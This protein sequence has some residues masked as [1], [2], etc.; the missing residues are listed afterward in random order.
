MVGVVQA[1]K[2]EPPEIVKP[3]GNV[4]SAFGSGL[5]H[6]RSGT[7]VQVHCEAKNAKTYSWTLNGIEIGKLT[8]LPGCDQA[9][10]VFKNGT[11]QVEAKFDKD[12]NGDYQCI[13]ANDLGKSITPYLSLIATGSATFDG[14]ENKAGQPKRV[15]RYQ[16][17]RLPCENVPESAPPYEIRWYRVDPKNQQESRVLGDKR[18]IVDPDGYVH[19]LWIEPDDND[20]LYYCAGYNSVMLSLNKNT[21]KYRL[22]VGTQ[23]SKNERPPQIMY[24]NGVT[25]RAG[26]PSPAKLMCI[27]AYFSESDL[28][29]TWYKGT[30]RLIPGDNF[31]IEE[32]GKVLLVKNIQVPSEKGSVEGPYTCKASLKNFPDVEADVQLTVIAPPVFVAGGRLNAIKAPLGSNAEFMCKTYSHRSHSKPVVWLENGE[33]IVGCIRPNDF[34]C[35]S[36]MDNG[37]SHCLN[38]AKQYCNAYP[39]CADESDEQGC[40]VKVCTEG[41]KACYG[42]CIPPTQDCIRD[43][44][45]CD[46][47][48]FRCFDNSSCIPPQK[49]CDGRKDCLDMSDEKACPGDRDEKVGRFTL[50]GDRTKLTLNN[51]SLGDTKCIQCMVENDFGTLFGDGCLTVIDKIKVTL[52]PNSSYIME[53]GDVLH[54]GVDAIG[55]AIMRNKLDFNWYW[56]T[57][58]KPYYQKLPPPEQSY[59]GVFELSHSDKK[60]TI[61]M[62]DIVEEDRESYVRYRNLTNRQY[63]VKIGYI[64]ENITVNFT[65]HGID[66][67][68]PVTKPTVQAAGGDLWWLA[69][70]IGVLFLIVVVVVIFCLC[71]RNR[72]GVYL[73]DKK[74]QK[75]GHDP[76]QELKDSGFHDVGRVG[77]DDFD[78]EKPRAEEVSLTE[79]VKPY[80][81]DDDVTEEYGGDFDVNK[82]NEDGSFIGVYVDKKN[83]TAKEA[84][85]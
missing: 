43:E 84:T 77:E 65:I 71:Y 39:D 80:D 76:E 26:D 50:A 22:L 41:L 46:Y 19:F 78:D 38:R 11:L 83:K 40:P 23:G 37:Y 27:F 70:I 64:Y 36:R 52:Q 28:S 74:E 58:E 30:D 21:M 2:E 57:A 61:R 53:P 60:L 82:F 6:V 55:D 72:G 17:M 69:I 24:N 79:S 4:W 8:S 14:V 54:L 47:P 59:W 29:I 15:Q 33:P 7:V 62:P 56:V 3:L 75:A 16:Y 44:I 42:K 66:I 31:E 68:P 73:L 20:W 51:V 35:K 18:I 12:C 67:A 1:Q 34:E 81:S 48:N 45:V 10:K 49:K 9:L 32:G 13:A 63:F 85:V 25:A 5:I